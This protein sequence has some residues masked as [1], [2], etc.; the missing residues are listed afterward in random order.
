MICYFQKGLKLFIKIEIK[1]QDWKSMDFEKMVQRAVNVELK[2]GLRSS[3]IIRES[4]ARCPKGHR[5]SHNT[6]SKVE[7]Q[8]T[9][10]KEPRTEKSTPKEASWSTARPPLRPALMSPLSPIAKRRSWSGSK[11]KRILLRQ[12]ETMPLRLRKRSEPLV[13]PVRWL[14]IIVRRRATLQINIPNF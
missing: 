4:D 1:Q 14:A 13:I 10:A 6:S 11:R 9:T 2:A 7:T 12:Q 8:E 5:P 3:K